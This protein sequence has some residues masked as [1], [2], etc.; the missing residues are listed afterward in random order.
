MTKKNEW[1]SRRA[2][3]LLEVMVAF[4][5]IALASGLISYKMQGAIEKKKL[6]SDVD[7]IKDR[8]R[9]VQKLAIASQSDWA[10]ILKKERKG[11]VFEVQSQEIDSK[12][13]KPLHIENIEVLFNGRQ[14]KEQLVFDFFATGHTLGE[15]ILSFSRNSHEMRLNLSD[16]FQRKE[17]Q[18]SGPNHPN[19]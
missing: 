18:Q 16:L 4:A 13:F 15:G 8:M 7:R 17:G 10:A 19:E 14:V 2:F 3:T 9:V 12:K 1:I 5:L 6:H 11:W